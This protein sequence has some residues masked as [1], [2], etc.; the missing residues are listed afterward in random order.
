MQRWFALP[1]AAPRSP[2]LEP[3][4]PPLSPG[5][6]LGREPPPAVPGHEILGFVGGGGQGE[7]YRARH[8][9]LGRTVA[10]KV[11]RAGQGTGP[12]HW[13]RFRREGRVIARLDHPNIVR[14]YGFQESGG[15]LFLSMEYLAG[16]SLRDRL[17]GQGFFAPEAAVKLLRTLA[18]AVEHAHRKG[19]V[20]RDLKPA[21]VLF[22]LDG[23]PKIVDF[24]LAKVVDDSASQQTRTGAILGSPSYMAPEQASGKVSQVG[25]ATDVYALGAILYELLTGRPPFSGESWL[26]T[27]DMVRFQ[28]VA[29][30]SHWRPNLPPGL[31]NVCLK[32]LE[33][34]LGE[35]YPSAAALAQ[36]LQPF[37]GAT[38]G[39][40]AGPPPRD[41]SPAQ[42]QPE[43]YRLLKRIHAGAFGEVWTAMA[44][45]D[46]KVAVKVQYQSAEKDGQ[47]LQALELV[48]GLDH[49]YL[50]KTHAYWVHDG[51]LRVVME[52]AD[53][54]LRDRLKKS[55]RQRGPG[56]P[57]ARLLPSLLEVA[58][59]LDF[60][61]GQQLVHRNV[62]PDNFLL[63]QGHAKLG[64][65][66]LLCR[67]DALG[68]DDAGSG[69]PG[70]MAP[71]CYRAV[72]TARSD[73]YSLAVSY[74]ELRRGRRPFPGRTS[75]A[76]AML[77]AFEGA[78]DLGDLGKPEK[79]VLLQALAK[80]PAQRHP[81][82]RAFAAALEAVVPTE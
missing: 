28:P 52:L 82:C 73:Q 80:D 32:C 68:P 74:V 75:L 17:I 43:G 4:G 55:Q 21:N 1:G 71:E 16:G 8:T 46:I 36:A 50:L 3:T 24:G 37:A 39:R 72:A 19:I 69:T 22:T 10:L 30:P 53:G 9:A 54:S 31:E 18:D 40:D 33:K 51:R 64:D 67:A 77:D 81:S 29:P 59:A 48:R 15:R 13:A 41:Q 26:D 34:N 63:V 65:F 76:E 70:Y 78:P 66:S 57:P 45:G 58:E 79:Q 56:I 5:E 25:P 44:P 62:R 38:P 35:R 61:H 2:T 27:L 42:G 47:L 20:H 6:A 14:V 23:R 7:V 60:L 11:L 49:P 12:E